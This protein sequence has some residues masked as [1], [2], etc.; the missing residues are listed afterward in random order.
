MFS[1]S[2]PIA[3]YNFIHKTLQEFLTAWYVS[4][5]PTSEQRVFMKDSLTKPNMAMTVRFMA[6]LTN[7]QTSPENMDALADIVISLETTDKQRF[8]E[9]LHWMFETQNPTFIQRLMGN[10]EQTF[11]CSETVL[12]PFDLHVLGYCIANSFTLWSVN[13]F[14]C[15]LTDECMRMLFLVEDGKAFHHITSFD[16]TGYTITASLASLLGKSCY[17]FLGMC[18][19]LHTVPESTYL[20]TYFSIHIC[21]IN[22]IMLIATGVGWG[23]HL[24]NSALYSVLTPYM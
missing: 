3:S 15:D 1:T 10:K 4:S 9:N 20:A 24:S 2:S 23:H 12:N 18:Y 14:S 16:L 11:K 21:Q 13:L 8:I 6:G 17:A 7:F 22:T 19:S 5:L